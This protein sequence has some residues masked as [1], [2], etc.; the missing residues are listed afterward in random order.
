MLTFDSFQT[1][2]DWAYVMSNSCRVVEGSNGLATVSQ[3]LGLRYLLKYHSRISGNIIITSK[4]LKFIL[5]TCLNGLP[6][7]GCAIKTSHTLTPDSITRMESGFEVRSWHWFLTWVLQMV[8]QMGISPYKFLNSMTS[9]NSNDSIKFSILFKQ[10]RLVVEE[11]LNQ[12]PYHKYIVDT[13][14]G[15]N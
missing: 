15:Y 14:T 3:S 10:I 12:L 6:L 9:L 7:G 11:G 2:A 8:F 13:P 4:T 1:L 5:Y